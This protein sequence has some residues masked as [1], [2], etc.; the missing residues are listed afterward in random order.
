MVEAAEPAANRDNAAGRRMR[1]AKSALRRRPQSPLTC[2]NSGD[3]A[4]RY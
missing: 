3:P 2:L 4:L 1:R